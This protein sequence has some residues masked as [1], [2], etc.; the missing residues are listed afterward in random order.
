MEV[1]MRRF[2]KIPPEHRVTFALE[3]RHGR[4]GLG[5]RVTPSEDAEH[6]QHTDETL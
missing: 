3:E 1:A 5:V 2:L 4:R 6:N